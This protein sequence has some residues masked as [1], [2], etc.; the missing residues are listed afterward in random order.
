MK[1][2]TTEILR[3]GLSAI[4]TISLVFGWMHNAAAQNS[5]SDTYPTSETAAV[6]N[7]PAVDGASAGMDSDV[8]PVSGYIPVALTGNEGNGGVDA[9]VPSANTLPAVPA[10][11][12]L[13]L[14]TPQAAPTAPNYAVPAAQG[15]PAATQPGYA[16]PDNGYVAPNSGYVAPSTG[17]TAPTGVPGYSAA[18]NGTVS[19]PQSPAPQSAPQSSS[20]LQSAPSA[21]VNAYPQSVTSAP[22]TNA[23]STAQSIQGE[24]ITEIPADAYVTSVSDMPMA[25]TTAVSPD[26]TE[27]NHFP[28]GLYSSPGYPH[29]N[30]D[31]STPEASYTPEISHGTPQR[32]EDLLPERIGQNPPLKPYPQQEAYSYFTESSTSASTVCQYCGEGY[33][34][35]YLWMVDAHARVMHRLR[36]RKA[37]NMI[38]EYGYNSSTGN[39]EVVNLIAP[40][41][42]FDVSLGVELG[43]TRYLGRNAF[44]YDI[45]AQLDF[46][47]L[48]KWAEHEDFMTN[49]F[50]ESQ[51]GVPGLNTVGYSYTP[52]GESEEVEAVSY[53]Q[54]VDL[55]YKSF[56][57]EGEIMLQFRKRGRPD[58]LVC[59]PN[60]RWTRQCQGGPRYTHQFGVR[61]ISYN[62]E[63]AWTGYG[64]RYVDGSFDSSNDITGRVEIETQNRM[65]GLSLGG[66]WLDKHCVWCW[67]FNWRVT[68]GLN[69]A[70][71][72][73]SEYSTYD[74][75][76]LNYSS[77]NTTLACGGDLGAFMRYKIQPHWVLSVEYKFN[78]VTNLALAA[79]NGTI[80]NNG[81]IMMENNTYLYFQ[82]LSLGST[83]VW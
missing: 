15:Y 58:P 62:E 45:W 59:Q 70:K 65:I 27:V 5:Y 78:I 40:N 75:L 43:L 71:A 81:E 73:I 10:D 61:Y 1:S 25:E 18:P 54:D 74:N 51:F 21:P 2:N 13:Q 38:Y 49:G 42:S 55:D 14:T 56:W 4:L 20:V 17:Y 48:H 7:S 28:N 6:Y 63:L 26:G 34:N 24:Y 77:S 12:A 11:T 60:G 53:S 29:N 68:P 52:E 22:V 35:P 33:G 46:S 16:M 19:V 23:P 76:Y 30:Y 39:T 72:E 32:K 69:F 36:E 83:F 37:Q 67:G 3:H 44:N 79:H 66:E 50:Y 57:N 64:N 41:A 31:N 47:G 8:V 82:T 9:G 80:Q